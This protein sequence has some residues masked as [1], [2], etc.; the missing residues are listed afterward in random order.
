MVVSE[1]EKMDE[2]AIDAMIISVSNS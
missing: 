2:F 1:E